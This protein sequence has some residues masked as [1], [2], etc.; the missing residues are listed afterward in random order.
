[1]QPRE[2]APLW[3]GLTFA[4]M[5]AGTVAYLAG[6]FAVEDIVAYMK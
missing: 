2:T 4:L 3:V 5:I 1:M 6:Y